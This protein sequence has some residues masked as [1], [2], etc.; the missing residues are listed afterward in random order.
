[1]HRWKYN[2]EHR[3]SLSVAFL[4]TKAA[5]DFKN[6]DIMLFT[7]L[8]WRRQLQRGFNQSEDLLRALCKLQPEVRDACRHKVYLSR[9][10][11]TSA[12]AGSNRADR[13]QNLKNA[14]KVH[15]DVSGRV[16]GIIDDV[17]TTGATGN[18]MAE[19]LLLAG[20]SQVH[21]YCLARTPTR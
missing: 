17:C 11:A 8:H 15:G 10:R 6:V 7:P 18:T 14:F 20:A 3:L 9:S 13:L 1:M 5:I 2:G 12:Q 19:A 4:M 16:V 21:L